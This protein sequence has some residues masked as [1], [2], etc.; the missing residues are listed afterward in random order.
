MHLAVRIEGI[1]SIS[2]AKEEKKRKNP[3][4]RSRGACRS[5]PGPMHIVYVLA[6]AAAAAVHTKRDVRDDGGSLSPAPAI[7]A[8][9]YT[10]V[11]VS[12]SNRFF[13]PVHSFLSSLLFFPFSFCAFDEPFRSPFDSVDFIF[14]Q[15]NIGKAK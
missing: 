1:V 12:L 6:A 7:W 13:L 8:L 9:A 15:L 3:F 10:R 14:L 11:I 4:I 5:F 2:R